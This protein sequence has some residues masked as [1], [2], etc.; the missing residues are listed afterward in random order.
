MSR[1]EL[2][3]FTDLA[4]T[5]KNCLREQSKRAPRQTPEAI[6]A[7]K[8]DLEAKESRRAAALQ[9]ICTSYSEK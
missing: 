9:K 1:R 8:R 2:S 4:A 6:L 7:L 5:R 3:S